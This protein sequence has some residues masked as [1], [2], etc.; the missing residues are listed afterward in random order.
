MYTYYF[1]C[2]ISIY[3]II[4]FDVHTKL[5]NHIIQFSDLKCMYEIEP[6]QIDGRIIQSSNI[7][8][9]KC[10]LFLNYICIII[11]LYDKLTKPNNRILQ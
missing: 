4:L 5:N 8:F 11:I 2:S 7:L 6:L 9:S 3:I 1:H 10:N